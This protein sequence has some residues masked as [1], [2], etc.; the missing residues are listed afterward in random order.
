MIL[1]FGIFNKNILTRV[2]VNTLKIYKIYLSS[3]R[4]KLYTIR[5]II[6]LQSVKIKKYVKIISVFNNIILT[7]F[8]YFYKLETYND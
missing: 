3:F 6:N 7:Y 1:Q 8:F 5:N 2:V 4:Y